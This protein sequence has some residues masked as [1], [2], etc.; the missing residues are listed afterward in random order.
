MAHMAK[1]RKY[2]P[3]FLLG[4]VAGLLLFSLLSFFRYSSSL[5]RMLAKQLQGDMEQRSRQ[6]VTLASTILE[7]L[8]EQLDAVSQFAGANQG[9]ND[10]Q[11]Q[12]L[13]HSLNTQQGRKVGVA[14]KDGLLYTA[15]GSTAD[16]SGRDYFRRALAGERVV[17]PV[18][19]DMTNQNQ[20]IVLAQPILRDGQV[21]GVVCG[22]YTV[23]MFT[24]LLGSSQFD[25]TGA[26]MI[27]Q[28]DGQMVSSWA[29]MADYPDFYA[30][31]ETMRFQQGESPQ[32][33][34]QA[35]EAGEARFFHYNNLKGEE[36]Y[37]YVEPAGISD[38]T[39]VSLV[40]ASALSGWLEKINMEA[41]GLLIL[42]LVIYAA[43]AA[44]G[45]RVYRLNQQV[46]R[47]N[48][49][50]VLTGIYNRGAA[51]SLMT[52]FLHRE[53]R[54]GVHACFFMDI[55]NFKGINDTLGHGAGDQLLVS[56]S[57]LLRESFRESDVVSR[58]G[59]DEFLI[60]MK[61]IND[62]RSAERKA[63]EL[64]TA[65]QERLGF[66]TVSIGIACYPD[67]SREYQILLE[68][69]D[70]AMYKA[71]AMGKNRF[72]FYSDIGKSGEE[73]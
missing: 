19:T 47:D 29:G 64:C 3:V 21:V 65:A 52:S 37:L 13:L 2:N 9:Q 73:G 72:L 34:R 15:S 33:L 48:Q 12:L 57:T 71:K 31:V 11:V 4:I 55:D 59:G 44:C 27:I 7:G 22:Q 67:D 23:E 10:P 24:Q 50:D 49:Q 43:V 40:E 17:S 63:L 25:E 70:Q 53:G 68:Q 66:P 46:L 26:T 16:V 51:V 58:Y 1:T 56:I 62:R 14:A 6:S 39:V 60:W 42:N 69:A 61:N 38:W 35:V 8:W 32:S 28:R 30:L 5:D 18:L 54:D 36:R 45:W 41:L 20:I